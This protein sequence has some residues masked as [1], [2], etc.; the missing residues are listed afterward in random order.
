MLPRFHHFVALTRRPEVIS[1]TW[2]IVPVYF[3]IPNQAIEKVEIFTNPKILVKE[4]AVLSNKACFYGR[5][6]D[7]K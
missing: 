5:P 4:Y 1:K 2:L 3:F 7:K 6:L